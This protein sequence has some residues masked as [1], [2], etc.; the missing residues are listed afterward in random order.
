MGAGLLAFVGGAGEAYF[1]GGDRGVE[2]V[3]R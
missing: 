3:I 1:F 2:A